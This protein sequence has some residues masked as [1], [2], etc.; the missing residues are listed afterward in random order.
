VLRLRVARARFADPSR[1]FAPVEYPLGAR[2]RIGEKPAAGSAAEESM[3]RRV[4]GN[5]LRLPLLSALGLG[6]A[7]VFGA[8]ATA[9]AHD[10]DRHHRRGHHYDRHYGHGSRHYG[11]DYGYGRSFR[12]RGHSEYYGG[13]AP[14]AFS[15]W[16]YGNGYRSHR[17]DR[18]CGH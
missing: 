15:P 5:A 8:A 1:R 4:L 2:S 14:Y 18:G 6:F 10:E 17:H 12:H 13:Y 11:R 16:G 7:L 3:S 9:S